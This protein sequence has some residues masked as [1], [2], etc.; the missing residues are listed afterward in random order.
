MKTAF[1]PGTKVRFK[2]EGGATARIVKYDREG[3]YIVEVNLIASSRRL[4]AHEDDME[5][6][7]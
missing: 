5:L 3:F 7:S 1:T 6:A 2:T 4:V